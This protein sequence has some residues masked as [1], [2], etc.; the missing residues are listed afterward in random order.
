MTINVDLPR[1][2]VASPLTVSSTSTDQINMHSRGVKLVINVTAV[3]GTSPTL[4][5]A[6]QGKD[7]ASGAYYNILS[8]ASI[9]AIGTTI[10]EIYP[11]I[12]NVAN[13]T[14]GVTLPTTWRVATTVGGTSPSFTA[15]IGASL[16]L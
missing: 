15:T 6:I 13:S 8:T 11:G 7:V 3:S 4:T 10:L 16:I 1:S 14:S 5:V 9:T 2:L 12:G